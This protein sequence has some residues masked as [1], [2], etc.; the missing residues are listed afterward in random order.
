MSIDEPVQTSPLRR[1]RAKT[2]SYPECF[3]AGNISGWTVETYAI[4]NGAL[5]S[6]DKELAEERDRRYTEIGIEREK[7]LKI[8]ETADL[9]A[10]SLARESQTYKEQQNDALRDKNLGESGLYAT[11]SSVTAANEA[12]KTSIAALIT[13]AA[14][15]RGAGRGNRTGKAELY[16]IGA[17]GISA[18]GA[19]AYLLR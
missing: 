10:L 18:V 13:D 11:N 15:A 19:L 4:Y 6:A 5:R 12:L 8:K 2:I 14:D 9:A 17:I 3:D 16:T 1:N 7:A